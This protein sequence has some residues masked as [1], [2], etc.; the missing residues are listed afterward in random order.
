MSDNKDNDYSIFTYPTKLNL[1][2]ESQSIIHLVGQ[3]L[4]SIRNDDY[5]YL[6]RRYRRGEKLPSKNYRRVRL[7]RKYGISKREADYIVFANS[8]QYQLV[9]RTTRDNIRNWEREIAKL[10]KK[11]PSLYGMKKKYTIDN[12]AILHK[13]IDKSLQKSPSC[14]FGSAKLQKKITQYYWDESLREDWDN[15]R[16]FLE[17]M[18]ESGKTYG[19]D[20]IKL[21]VDSGEL[22]LHISK[23]MQQ[24]LELDKRMYVLGTVDVK[25]GRIHV[26]NSIANRI[27][28]AYQFHWD[29]NK[30]V[31]RLHITT[32]V[33]KEE[34]RRK[35]GFSY[36]P[37]RA[38][39]IDQNSGFVSCTIVDKHGNPIAQRDFY[40]THS[41]DIQSLVNAIYNWLKKNHCNTVYIEQ[42]KGLS[43]NK[44][45][46]FGRAKAL[47]RT[48]NEIP[49]YIFSILMERKMDICGGS[50]TKVNPRNT[51]KNTVFW[52]DNK[53]GRTIHHKASY[54]IARRGKNLSIIP[55]HMRKSP[56]DN[57]V[58]LGVS[59][60]N[61]GAELANNIHDSRIVDDSV[62][63]EYQ[64]PIQHW[65]FPESTLVKY[66]K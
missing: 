43:L 66:D 34:L 58:C 18:G 22:S 59:Y 49:Y 48:I 57:R 3:F 27:A 42:L 53:Y 65:C 11:L 38:C 54:L 60:A 46:S 24:A 44:R 31:W 39:G 21:D 35:N 45:K 47:N 26:K 14:C 5:A 30:K 15:K 2:E 7:M 55:R 6:V 52:E 17:F 20:S 4:G 19:N 8:E 9:I 13:K 50:C 64:L 61:N 29:S 1:T 63:S 37:G 36:I 23:G 32:R 25:N 62:C 28:T 40:H 12:I 56:R 41:K 51:S 33:N 10:Q 16:L